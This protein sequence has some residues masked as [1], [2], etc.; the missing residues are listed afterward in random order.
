MTK[1]SIVLDLQ[2]VTK[3]C[4]HHMAHLI[5]LILTKGGKIIPNIF[6]VVTRA[7]VEK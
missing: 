3:V 2:I 6:V 5:A 1:L 7:Q 4:L